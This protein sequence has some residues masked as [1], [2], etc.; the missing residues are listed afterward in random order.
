M[1]RCLGWSQYRN[2]DSPSGLKRVAVMQSV[3]VSLEPVNP[4][5][6]AAVAEW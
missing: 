4:D 5:T 2:C 1:S 3:K 6:Y